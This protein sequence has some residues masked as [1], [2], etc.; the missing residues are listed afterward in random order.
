M[1][2]K[3]QKFIAEVDVDNLP[4]P[5]DEPENIKHETTLVEPIVESIVPV[6]A[7]VKDKSKEA[8][9]SKLQKIIGILESKT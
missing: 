4:E 2:A 8:F 9:A 6:Q 5:I 7:V 3:K 1:F